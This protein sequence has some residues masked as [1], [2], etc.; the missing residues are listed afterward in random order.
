MPQHQGVKT[1]REGQ[2]RPRLVVAGL[3][4]GALALAT[5]SASSKPGAT[6]AVDTSISALGQQSSIEVGLSLPITPDQVQQLQ[7]TSGDGALSAAAAKALSGGSIFVVEQTGHGEPL[8]SPSA[9]TDTSSSY[10]LGLR[11]GS[12]TPVEVRYVAQTLFLH[13]QLAQLL[14]DVGE[15]PSATIPKFDQGLNQANQYVPGL[16]SLGEGQWVEVSH[17]SLQALDALLKKAESSSG[18]GSMP[19]PSQ[20]VPAITK[21]RSQAVAALE[22]DSIVSSLG[23][24]G[25]RTGYSVTFEIRQFLTQIEPAIQTFLSSLGPAASTATSQLHSSWSQLEAKVPSGQT[26]V[27]DLYTSSGHL[28]QASVDLNQFAGAQKVGFPVPL[29]FSFGSPPVLS[30]PT[31]SAALDLSRVASLLGSLGSRL[32]PR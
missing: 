12:D 26:A 6:R 24:T 21:F 3:L 28:V 13:L 11:I 22:Q 25:G 1:V 4:A 30:A 15:N 23:T 16:S 7:R 32:T 31:N 20:L 5:C 17:S 10:D 19:T 27:A 14:S 8:D 2:R 18:S 9:A 29:T